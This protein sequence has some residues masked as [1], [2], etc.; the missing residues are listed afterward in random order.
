MYLA[1]KQIKKKTHYFLR[2]S[3]SDGSVIHSRDLFDLG[4]HPEAYIIYPDGGNTFY[5]DEGLCDAIKAKGV[6]PDSGLMEAVL[7]PFLSPETR[8]LLERFS[9]SPAGRTKRLAEEKKRCQTEPF[10]M[11][12]KRRIHYLRY[13]EIDQSSLSRVP[14]KIYRKLLDKSRDEIEQ[15]FLTMEQVLQPDEKKNYVFAAFNIAGHFNSELARK[16]PLALP[17]EKVDALFMEEICRLND[18]AAFWSHLPMTDFLQEYLVRYACWFFDTDFAG[19]DYLD[20][21]VWQFKRRHHGFRPPPPRSH[22]PEEEAL[23]MLGIEPS[24]LKGM[25]VKTLTQHYRRMA[26][27]YH[28]DRGGGHDKFIRLTRAF[29][30]VLRRIKTDGKQPHYNTHRG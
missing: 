7:W 22:M 5:F 28:P 10:H 2:Q 8:R 11:F 20:D 17:E 19:G 23:A 14:K 18:D 26:K 25:T 21:L 3:I 16:F 4:C 24:E 30:D 27:Q 12:D 29:E 15:Q 9:R 13:G 1:R 6:E